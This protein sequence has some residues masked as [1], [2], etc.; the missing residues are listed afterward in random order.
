MNQTDLQ[1]RLAPLRHYAG[2]ITGVVDQATMDAVRECLTAAVSA[3]LTDAQVAEAA[4]AI[5]V[6]PAILWAVHDVGAAMLGATGAHIAI[7][8]EPHR[9]SRLTS[10]RFDEDYP[11]LS[12]RDWDPALYPE[13]VDGRWAQLLDAVALDVD[14]AFMATSYGRFRVLG[15]QH[16]ACG[17]MDPWSFAWE[18]SLAPDDQLEAFVRFVQFYGLAPLLL[19]QDWDGFARAHD[20][21]AARELDYAAQLSVA[22]AARLAGDAP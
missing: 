19:A 6:A 21:T 8:F 12:S 14:A 11:A 13:G 9:F 10:Q 17:A 3:P 1:R 2:P 15:Q 7:R 5:G 4:A 20:G 16:H 18:E 22:H